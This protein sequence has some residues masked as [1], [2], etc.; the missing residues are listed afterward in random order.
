MYC[1]LLLCNGRFWGMPPSCRALALREGKIYALGTEAELEALVG[2]S[3]ERLDLEDNLV[4]PGLWDAHLHLS[5]WSRSRSHLHLSDCGSAEEVLEKVGE[6]SP[7]EE[8]IVGWHLN[9]SHWREPKLPTRSQLDEVSADRPLILWLS[10]LHSALV[11]TRALQRAGLMVGNPAVKGGVVEL[12]N[13]GRPTGLLREMAA[14]SVRDLIPEP[15]QAQLKQILQEGIHT[16]HQWGI[17]GVCDQRIKDLDDGA[18]VFRALRDLEL[19]ACL[20]LRVSCNVAA[21]HLEQAAS[22]GLSTG[23]GTDRLKLGHL[24]IFSDGTLGSKTARML[25]PLKGE[26]Q[27]GIYLTPPEEMAETL[28]RAAGTGFS[29]SVHSIGD[30]SNRVCLDLFEQLRSDGS[31]GLPVP[32][33]IE[34]VQL[35]DD[36]DLDRFADLNLTVSAQPGHA[37][38]DRRIADDLLG[39]RGRTAYRFQDFQASGARL[40]FGSDGP[41]SSVDPRYGLQAA[42]HRRLPGEAAWYPEQCLSFDQALRAYTL[43]AAQAAGWQACG[44]L[45]K[46]AWGDL[47]V[48]EKGVESAENLLAASVL[49]TISGGKIVH[50]QSAIA[51]E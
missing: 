19:E 17:T 40:A 34:H 46:G 9:M 30:E 3:T 2:P 47:V 11:N 24:K 37:L 25:K 43:G 5:H 7:Q 38:D 6:T 36:R 12:D 41:V 42:V 18:G 39:P 4:T 22:L 33:R 48:W 51:A 16:L 1:E 8:W 10:D 35:V 44:V 15:S 45:E 50:R 31:G 28:Q 14:N 26:E 32:H 29:V 27:R 13:K 49:L 21:H 20:D 23:F